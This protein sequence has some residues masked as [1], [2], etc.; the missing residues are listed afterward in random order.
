MTTT[1]TAAGLADDD[2]R[3]QD[4]PAWKA[5]VA[6][7]LDFGSAFELEVTPWMPPAAPQAW[8]PALRTRREG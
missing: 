6:P 4:A 8:R 1:L 5:S 2:T 3:P 7:T